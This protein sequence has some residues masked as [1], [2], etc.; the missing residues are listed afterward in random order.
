MGEQPPHRP[1]P[2][3]AHPLA[4]LPAGGDRRGRPAG[5]EERAHGQDRRA[6]PRTHP[7]LGVTDPAKRERL[8]EDRI[9]PLKGA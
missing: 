1:R 6:L 9:N 8:G 2:D 7:G 3:H 4:L 5:P